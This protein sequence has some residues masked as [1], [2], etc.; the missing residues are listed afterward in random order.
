[1]AL[2]IT[3]KRPI[4]SVSLPKQPVANTF[5]P[6]AG[7]PQ[8]GREFGRISGPLLADN[9]LRN[10]NDI[11]F[12]T[13]LLYL[14]VT[15]DFVGI[16]NSTPTRALD[17][18]S[19]A[20]TD[21]LIVDTETDINSSFAITT[22]QITNSLNL[23]I[24]ISP[25][26]SSNPTIVVNGTLTGGQV[27]FNSNNITVPI[28]TVLNFSPTT[29]PQ[30][31]VNGGFET[32]DLSGWS[33]NG[34]VATMTVVGGSAYA[35]SG[36]YAI[37]MA[38]SISY[39]T[40][41]QTL[42]TSNGQTYTLTFSLENVYDIFLDTEN[43]AIITTEDGY[44]ILGLTTST[45]SGEADFAVYWNGVKLTNI[46]ITSG[47]GPAVPYSSPAAIAWNYTQYSA[48]V[49]GTGSDVLS[50][51]IRNDAGRFYLDNVSVSPQGVTAGIT[52]INSN[53]LVNGTLH[54]TGNIT[55]DGNIVLGSNSS[56]TIFIPAEVNSDIIPYATPTTI[57][58]V[59]SLLTDQLGN[60]LTDQLG[61]SLYTNPGAPY[62]STASFN[63]GSSSLEWNNVWSN[64]VNLSMALTTSTVTSTTVNSGNINISGNTISD[65]VADLTL[66]PT[67]TGEVKFNGFALFTGNSINNPNLGN[68]YFQTE[69]GHFVITAEN[70]T[71]IASESAST[72]LVFKNTGIGYV[73]FT[74]TGAM[75]I[76]TGT[77][78]DRPA[79]PKTGQTRYNAAL[80]YVEIYNGTAWQ[81]I[82]GATGSQATAQQASDLNTIWSLILG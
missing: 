38:S 9:L 41:A 39:S 8:V 65:S 56:N 79:V 68:A 66:T 50:F 15:G 20:T 31:V 1:M 27:S 37:S 23:P 55:F 80:G 35:T 14:N 48:T 46:S 18:N 58:P 25:N 62:S 11:A 51:V 28:N 42:A 7:S 16:N 72:P 63:L 3:P 10:G 17:I 2:K 78:A 75:Q 13:K 4:Q 6:L 21:N 73:K 67:G 5:Q 69:S 71:I 54:A 40:L 47:A 32:G 49:T 29:T 43:T 22:N 53:T 64:N 52:Q 36:N 44:N 81:D 34:S 77:T 74:G 33:V 76:P 30:F 45:P 24:I 60:T 26:Q 12:E 82:S 19:N 59:T 61:N 57:T 70:S